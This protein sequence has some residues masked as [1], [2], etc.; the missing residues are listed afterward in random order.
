MGA[1]FILRRGAGLP[2][3]DL[4]DLLRACLRGSGDVWWVLWLGHGR[5]W[6]DGQA[7]ATAVP[8]VS[9][10]PDMRIRGYELACW[11]AGAAGLAC[12]ICL[13]PARPACQ[14]ALHGSGMQAHYMGACTKLGDSPPLMKIQAQEQASV[15]YGISHAQA[16][17]K[18]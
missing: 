12:L 4:P 10:Y 8:D 17:G 5:A 14:S 7:W 3:L 2:Y 13:N 9:G 15:K 11:Q 1:R 6:L 18:E 16:Q